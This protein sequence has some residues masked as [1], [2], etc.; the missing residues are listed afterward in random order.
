MGLGSQGRPRRANPFER[1]AEVYDETREELDTPTLDALLATFSAEGRP[2]LLEVGVGTGRVA[3]PLQERGVAVTGL[4]A[5]PNMIR[6]AR[7]KGV[8]D[9]VL[10]D[11]TR[12]P[13]PDGVFDLS[14]FVHVLGILDD[15]ATVLREAS[16]VSRRGVLA[17]V[18]DYARIGTEG[19]DKEQVR[20]LVR[21]EVAKL[22]YPLPPRIPASTKERETLERWPPQHA[23]KVVEGEVV[24][25]P[26][27]KLEW[28]RKGADR[29]L[30]DVPAAAREMSVPRAR[31]RLSGKPARFRRTVRLVRWDSGGVA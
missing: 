29:T 4:D 15:P 25:Y 12:M 28:I 30:L 16:R 22:G 23:R 24:E 2:Q 7:L 5:S 19:E 18:T 20:S 31:A 13:F 14:L 6:R 11:A 26:D 9:L 17:V 21:E 3:R 10:G 8:A 27:E 1:I